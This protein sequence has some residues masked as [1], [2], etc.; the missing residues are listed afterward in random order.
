MDFVFSPKQDWGTPLWSFIHT[1]T[2]NSHPKRISNDEERNKEHTKD[3]LEVT[4]NYNKYVIQKLN[5]L[6][7]LIICPTCLSTYIIHLGYLEDIDVSE[8]MVLFKWS[9]ELHNEVNKKLNK[10]IFTYKNA[11]EMWTRKNF[12]WREYNKETIHEDN[13]ANEQTNNNAEPTIN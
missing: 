8:E 4:I 1:I 5:A 3:A 11:L 13:I 10:P 7:E 2:I 6:K 9:V 12:F